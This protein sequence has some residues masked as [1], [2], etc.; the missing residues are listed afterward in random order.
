MFIEFFKYFPNISN[1]NLTNTLPKLKMFTNFSYYFNFCN[2]FISNIYKYY[3]L[4][5]YFGIL[6]EKVCVDKKGIAQVTIPIQYVKLN[7]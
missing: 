5:A 7:N 1:Q 3:F 4:F 2:Y 6:I